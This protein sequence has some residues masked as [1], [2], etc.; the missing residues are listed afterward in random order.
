MQTHFVPQIVDQNIKLYGSGCG[1]VGSAVASNT[2]VLPTP[3]IR[4]SNPVIGKIYLPSTVLRTVMKRQKKKRPRGTIFL[5][6][7][8]R[9]L[10]LYFRFSIQL[11]IGKQMF[12]IKSCWWLDSNRRPL[13]F[14]ATTLPTEP[15]QN[16]TILKVSSFNRLAFVIRQN[17]ICNIGPQSW[18]GY[19]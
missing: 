5:M 2:R 9:P 10:F 14:E 11:T 1:T 12:Y 15:L 3:E 16:G 8:S 4:G 6:C 19:S 17:L 13:E 7:H 18:Y